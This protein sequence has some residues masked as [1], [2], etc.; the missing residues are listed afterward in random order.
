MKI[1]IQSNRVV[2]NKYSARKR[3][4]VSVKPGQDH[5]R[6]RRLLRPKSRGLPQPLQAVA[7]RLSWGGGPFFAAPSRLAAGL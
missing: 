5:K 2:R 7:R 6:V 1:K 4:G 3:C